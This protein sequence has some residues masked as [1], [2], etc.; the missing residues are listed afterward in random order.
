[1]YSQNN[2]NVVTIRA[3]K[4]SSG[5]HDGVIRW[6]DAELIVEGVPPDG[7]HVCAGLK[8]QELSFPRGVVS[9]CRDQD[10]SVIL[11]VPQLTIPRTIAY[12]GSSACMPRTIPSSIPCCAVPHKCRT[13][14]AFR[15]YRPT[16][17]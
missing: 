2:V 12:E 11:R 10:H 4:I 3:A 7:L 17:R 15:G 13:P 16:L 6:R 5:T 9:P 1:M 14:R 8:V